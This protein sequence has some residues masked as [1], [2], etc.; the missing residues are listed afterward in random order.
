VT[1]I[2]EPS[3]KSRSAARPLPRAIADRLG[4]LRGRLRTKAL[5]SGA[6]MSV[7]A[8]GVFIH[9]TFLLDRLLD[10]PSAFRGVL[11]LLG[12]GSIAA[13]V[14]LK[15]L[16][17]ASTPRS[18]DDL[19]L[20]LE[21]A[22]PALN[23]SLISAVQ[24][25]RG[26]SPGT[27]E[28]LSDAMVGAVVA[29]AEARIASVDDAKVEV[30][31]GAGRAALLALVVLLVTVFLFTTRERDGA[32]WFQRMILLSDKPWPRTVELDDPVYAT[33]VAK[34]DDV[35]VRVRVTRGAPTRIAV[36]AEFATQGR[37]DPIPM[38]DERGEWRTTLENVAEPFRFFIEGGDYRSQWFK[39]D[40]RARPRVELF[41]AWLGPPSYTRL[42]DTPK[43]A[44]LADLNVKVPGGTLVLW[45]ATS[46]SK[47][48]AGELLFATPASVTEVQAGSIASDG[49]TFEGRF[50]V[51]DS[52]AVTVRLVSSEGFETP[53]AAQYQVRAITDRLPDVRIVKPGRNKDVAKQAL[54]SL[55]VEVKDDYQ[56]RA[57]ALVT[58]LVSAKAPKEPRPEV[59]TPLAGLPPTE[60]GALQATL[61]HVID[62]AQMDG[63]VAEG[64]R[65]TYWVEA[66]DERAGEKGD[67]TSVPP[68]SRGRS[69]K[70]VLS[71]ISEDDLLRRQQQQLKRVQDDLAAVVKAE[72]ATAADMEAL[73]QELSTRTTTDPKDKRRLTYA[74]LDHRKAA[75][76][77]E[78]A[79]AAFTEVKEEMV[80]NKVGKDEDMR[81]VGDL[82][83]GADRLV[84]DQA[85]RASADLAKLRQEE[86][87]QASKVAEVARTQRDLVEG[88]EEIVRR[89]QKWDEANEVRR[90]G[91]ELLNFQ[92]RIFKETQERAKQELNK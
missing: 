77:L 86:R 85:A 25:S 61:E 68:E 82:E 67:T 79:R 11:L 55:K 44:P 12:A 72:K 48:K 33:V 42:P 32:I 2:A 70:Y 34:G 89:L 58:Q 39:V 40:V 18:D 63:G 88:I 20:L 35:E 10:L 49:R 64:D 22:H 38:V 46:S 50:R 90:D 81:W 69:E 47:L 87:P 92:E 21:R 8:V 83:A 31:Q 37:T 6:A 7:L 4:A 65:I 84:K 17:P 73:S 16:R 24:L 14:H 80:A 54:V 15:L 9:G 52:T 75:Q 43:G 26:A 1:A 23:D 51:K 91:Q 36:T 45:R 41:E 60:P 29:T 59:R 62:L 74:E 19:A 76:R 30:G 27:H 13:V 66:V 28:V 53:A 3:R 5:V 57:A 71:V 78:T 56:P